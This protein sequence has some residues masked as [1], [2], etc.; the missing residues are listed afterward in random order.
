MHAKVTKEFPGRP[1]DEIK[2]RIIEVDEIITGD[3]AKVAIREKWA[4]KTKPPKT[5][6]E[7]AAEKAAADKV[8]ADKVAADKAAAEKAVK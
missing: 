8:A 7:L 5:E 6:E 4:K 2:T 3:L 1:D